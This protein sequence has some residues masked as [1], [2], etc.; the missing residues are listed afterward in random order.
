MSGLYSKSSFVVKKEQVSKVINII[1]SKSLTYIKAEFLQND[2]L[3]ITIYSSLV[4]K[5][6]NAFSEMNFERNFRD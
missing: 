6:K 3:K 5:Y 4:E 1:I 2:D